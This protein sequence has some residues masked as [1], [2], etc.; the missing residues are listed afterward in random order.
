[1]SPASLLPEVILQEIFTRYIAGA[2]PHDG[3]Q[4]LVAVSR[5]WRIVAISLMCRSI[6]VKYKRYRIGADTHID[7]SPP[8][9]ITRAVSLC[10]SDFT[11][12]LTIHCHGLSSR[13]IQ[14]KLMGDGFGAAQWPRLTAVTM[15]G[16]PTEQPLFGD[17]RAFFLQY[18]PNLVAVQVAATVSQPPDV[19]TLRSLDPTSALLSVDV[20]QI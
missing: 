2:S 13:E 10:V 17:L 3:G 20:Q 6:T 4:T 14:Q 8:S 1:M 12:T 18:A 5:Q 7:L 11:H 16:L 15:H 9:A 19:S